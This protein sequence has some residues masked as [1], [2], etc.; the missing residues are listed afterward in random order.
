MF[1]RLDG[2][3]LAHRFQTG[4]RT[5]LNLMNPPNLIFFDAAGTLF[6]V[7]GSVGAIYAE[8]A[9]RY[10]LTV[11]VA[12]LEP[13]FLAAFRAQPPLSAPAGLT[14]AEL[15]QFEYEWWRALVREVFAAWE[16]PRVDDCFAELFEYFRQPQAWRVFDDV[17]PTL[18]ALQARGCALAV[19]SNFDSR[20][21]DLVTSLGLAPYFVHVHYST[22]LGAAKPD[23]RSFHTAVQ[24]HGLWPDEAW[25]VG[26]SP[27]ED[28]AGAQAAGLT[29]WLLE[30]QNP[31][32]EVRA[33]SINRLTQLLEVL[34]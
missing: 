27:R 14:A 17:L 18:Q 15:R 4:K 21:L 23:P 25:H 10:G 31:K 5:T 24:F 30:R 19:L 6:E 1:L 3:T 13:R 22:R 26:D 34:T 2:H 16:F 9:A 7:R 29:G 28:L 8:H 11:S 33:H 20:L 32:A 12:E